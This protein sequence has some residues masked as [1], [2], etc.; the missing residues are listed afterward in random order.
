M[1]T[2]AATRK[3]RP[4]ARKIANARLADRAGQLMRK[5]IDFI[6]NQSFAKRSPRKTISEPEINGSP[7]NLGNLPAHLA[8]MC[9]TQLLTP[10]E[11]KS[12]FEQ[13]NFLKFRANMLRSRLNP[14]TA[15][16]EDIA[17]IE[18]LLSEAGEVRDRLIRANMRL[19]ISVVKKY[20]TPQISFDDLLSEGAFALMHAV[21]KFDFDRGF[22]FSTYAYRAIARSCYR[23]INQRQ[24]EST[25]LAIV[26]DESMFEGAE[27]T[28]S[29]SLD[30]HTWS[31]LRGLLMK[32]LHRLDRRDQMIIRCRYALGVHRK[33][34]SFQRIA[35]KLGLSKERV[36]QLEQRAVL[37]LQAMATEL[38]AQDSGDRELATA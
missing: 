25:R 19:V 2:A 3:R 22:R 8:R 13:M 11:E 5:E 33:V 32:L 28:R 24:K 35:D 18:A 36:R 26:G 37:K 29:S 21:D 10:E 1:I 23:I 15:D 14:A 20:V 9:S 6:P 12:L 4:A 27:D 17:K 34:R 38:A 30:E 16:A 7:K 31:R